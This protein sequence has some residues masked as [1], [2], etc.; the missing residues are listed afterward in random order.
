MDDDNYNDKK[1]ITGNLGMCNLHHK[2]FL[3]FFFFFFKKRFNDCMVK[4]G[5]G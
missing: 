5:H 2:K 3:I 1:F 4:G